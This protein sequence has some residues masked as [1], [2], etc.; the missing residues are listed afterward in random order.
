MD[1]QYRVVEIPSG[2]SC[3]NEMLKR[4]PLAAFARHF[5][6]YNCRLYGKLLKGGERPMKCAECIA[7]QTAVGSGDLF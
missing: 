6:A 2:E 7:A 3:V 4:C 1:K 5:K